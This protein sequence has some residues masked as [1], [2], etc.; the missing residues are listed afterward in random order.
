MVTPAAERAPG[1]TQGE[2]RDAE[3]GVVLA[4]AVPAAG[5]TPGAP[6]SVS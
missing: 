1:R 4:K 3:R 6:M 2:M 5:G